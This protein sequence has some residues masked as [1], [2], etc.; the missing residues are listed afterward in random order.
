MLASQIREERLKQRE[1]H[2]IVS[3]SGITSISPFLL[4]ILKKSRERKI[5]AMGLLELQL[6]IAE[7][8]IFCEKQINI[9][10]KISD[11]ENRNDAWRSREIYKAHRKMLK[12]V[13]DGVAF[14]LLNFER[15]VLRQ[16]V[17][18]N[19]SGHLS[20][21]FAEEI[22]KAE[23]IVSETGYYV[24]LNDLTNF[25]RYGDLTIISPEG[26]II[27][28]VKTTGKARGS[29][30]KALAELIN[31]LNNNEF[32]SGSQIAKYIRVPGKPTSFIN[33]IERIITIS[34]QNNEG[35]YSERISP[36]LWVS[37]TSIQ[38]MM[39]YFKKAGK[40]PKHS[41]MPFPKSNI[42]SFS[43]SLMFFNQFA[44]N[45]M[46]YSVFPFS[47]EII[48]EIMTG[49]IQL[50][51]VV[52]E[53]ELI[54]SF[55]G[56]GWELTLLPR[57]VKRAVYDVDDI[58]KIKEAVNNPKFH[59]ILKKDGFKYTLPHEI[60]LRIENEFRSVKSF[61]DESEEMMKVAHL[62][63]TPELVATNFTEESAIWK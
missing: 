60:L 4:E 51:V 36:Y 43:D 38:N 47:E 61:I 46:P 27:D 30:K 33:K 39:R 62:H 34:K 26:R 24:I 3:N 9:F 59:N 14:R 17:E 21:G 45:L 1:I 2:E 19:G 48:C 42:Y 28:E 8:M 22:N 18:H 55:K 20:E 57:E 31:M 52:G 49:Q 5:S 54:K 13:M 16:L 53:K 41:I 40:L 7:K 50:K 35:I 29:Q 6:K 23:Y 15:P 10:K 32:K 12:E 37:S 58:N 56:K 11:R 63:R 44:P 25:L